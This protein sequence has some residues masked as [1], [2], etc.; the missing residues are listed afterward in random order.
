M[1]PSAVKVVR[2]DTVALRHGIPAPHRGFRNGF[3]VVQL[4]KEFVQWL[5]L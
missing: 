4:N 3:I 5:L 1:A 2:K